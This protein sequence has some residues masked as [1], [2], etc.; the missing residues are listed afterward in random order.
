MNR[1]D[2]V[3]YL[4]GGTGNTTPA[5]SIGGAKSN[6]AKIDSQTIDAPTNVTGVVIEDSVNNALGDG[7]L[8]YTN[9]GTTLTW[10]ENGDTAGAAV[11]VSTNGLYILFT[12]NGGYI[13]VTVTAGSLP[14]SDQNDAD[15]TV[16]HNSNNLWD[17]ISTSEAVAGDTEYRCIYLQN[18]HAS[19][20][21]VDIR[22][23]I[24]VDAPGADSIALG[25]D[26]AGKERYSSNISR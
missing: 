6:T 1:G 18:D 26:P 23:Y 7:T 4:S 5:N 22:V 19:Q 17:D 20:T 9:S 24:S 2:L 13:V 25:L 12:N 11:D 10:A 21:G 15:L 14:G 16:A 3:H 8:T